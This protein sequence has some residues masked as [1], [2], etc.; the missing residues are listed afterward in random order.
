VSRLARQV[1]TA[2]QLSLTREA[3]A[4][5]DGDTLSAAIPI[6][7]AS[8]SCRKRSVEETSPGRAMSICIASS[9]AGEAIESTVVV[10]GNSILT[11]VLRCLT[12]ATGGRR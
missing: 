4:L 8:T 5:G 6:C 12:R 2:Y 10:G 9:S 11:S 1:E 7:L 3:G